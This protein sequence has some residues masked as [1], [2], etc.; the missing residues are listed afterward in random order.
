MLKSISLSPA[1][2][3]LLLTSQ[4]SVYG[5][6]DDTNTNVDVIAIDIHRVT[7]TTT[8]KRA[9]ERRRPKVSIGSEVVKKKKQRERERVSPLYRIYDNVL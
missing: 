7:A 2:L 3:L 4:Y 8:I 5:S 9:L 1:P 6:V